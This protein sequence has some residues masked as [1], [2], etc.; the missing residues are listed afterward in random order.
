MYEYKLPAAASVILNSPDVRIFSHIDWLTHNY[1]EADSCTFLSVPQIFGGRLRSY[2]TCFC[3][4]ISDNLC[5]LRATVHT[6]VRLPGIG[7]VLESTLLNIIKETYEDLAEMTDAYLKTEQ[8]RLFLNHWEATSPTDGASDTATAAAG[9]QQT[10]SFKAST[11]ADADSELEDVPDGVFDF[12]GV[13][14]A[15][16]EDMQ[17]GQA[18][19]PGGS[20]DPEPARAFWL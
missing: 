12:G 8:A 6:E 16:N 18:D 17:R 7:R 9:A 1:S 3:V 14:W 4:P 2:G 15:L 10:S 5:E 20:S 13:L 19:D 11:A